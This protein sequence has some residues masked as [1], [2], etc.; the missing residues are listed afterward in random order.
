MLVMTSV[1]VEKCVLF[2][3]YFLYST[4]G[5]PQTLRGPVVTFPYSSFGRVL[6]R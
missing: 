3:S 5:A 6:V 4:G 1:L 2:A